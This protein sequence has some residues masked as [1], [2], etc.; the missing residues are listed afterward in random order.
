MYRIHISNMFHMCM[1][2]LLVIWNINKV[3]LFESFRLFEN[4]NVANSVADEHC[5]IKL[6]ANQLHNHSRSV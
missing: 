4:I 3:S 1:C 5:I 6:Y 2:V